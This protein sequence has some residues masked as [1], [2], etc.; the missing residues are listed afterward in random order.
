MRAYPAYYILNVPRN[1]QKCKYHRYSNKYVYASV[2][3]YVYMLA[4]N[5]EPLI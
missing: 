2:N 4:K 3:F 5:I 1:G